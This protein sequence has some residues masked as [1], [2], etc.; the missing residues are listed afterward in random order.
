[1]VG[2]GYS[3]FEKI[4]VAVQDH[5]FI[6]N[7]S[8]RITR[9]NFFKEFL[10]GDL[11]NAY[12]NE[13]NNIPE[14]FNR[15][16]SIKNTLEQ[17]GYTR[18]NITDT[19]IAA[20]LGA[21]YNV[22]ERPVI[23][24]DVGNGHTFAALIYDNFKTSSFFEHHTTMLTPEKMQKYIKKMLTST[25]TFEDVYN[26]GG[27]GAHCFQKKNFSEAAIYVTGPQR[28]RLF[29]NFS[30]NVIYASPAG[31]T[32]ITGPVGLLLQEQLI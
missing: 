17:S 32:M 3:D 20:A 13:T 2:A 24:V 8:D 27:H 12:F 30:D 15:L 28:H 21:L 5:G 6:K 19:G 10:K 26:D 23:T 9:I 22:S 31:D 18:F 1:M 4:L 16:K 14:G 25:I 11:R 7:Q 29:D